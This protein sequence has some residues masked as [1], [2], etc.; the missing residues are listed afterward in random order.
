MFRRN[1]CVSRRDQP[2]H[3]HGRGQGHRARLQAQLRRQRA[4][5]SPGHR[6]DARSR[7]GRP[8][9]GRGVQVRPQLH[10]A[11]GQYRVPRERRGPRDGDDGHHQAVWRGA[12][13]LP[14]RGRWRNGRE[15]HRG[16]QDHAEEPGARGD[17]REYLRRHHEMRRDRGRVR[18]SRQAGQA[19]GA[20]GVP[21]RRDQR[22]TRKED[23]RRLGPA[24][25]F[26]Q[27]HGRRACVEAARQVKLSVPLVCRLEGTNVELGKKILADS[28]L[29]IISANNM[30]DAA[31]KVVAAAAGRK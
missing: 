6:R 16:L 2:A 11:R 23:P 27:R 15:S 30:V 13:Q 18:R 4:L 9:R 21:A 8:R 24:D 25:H 3:Y 22:R 29:P 28:G 14:R 5:P 17:P 7:R 10:P 1:G 19:L 20:A 31:Q 26:R 12:G